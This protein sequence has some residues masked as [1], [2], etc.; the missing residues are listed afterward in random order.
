MFYDLIIVARSSTPK[1][2]QMTQRCIDSAGADNTILVETSGKS[3]TYSGIN[4]TVPYNEPF[5]Y[6][7]A[8][9]IGLLYAKGDIHVLANNDLVF[10]EGWKSIGDYMNEY[11]F[12]SASA[13]SRNS[14]FP[15]GDFIY[16]GF[17]IIHHVTGWCLF[18][19]AEAYK[20]IGKLDES[21]IFW[22]SDNVYATQLQKHKLRHGLFCN[23]R[24]DHITSQ[25]LNMM[26]RKL[27]REYSIGQLAK[28]E[29][30]DRNRER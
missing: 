7:H 12:D 20:K 21:V 11:G 3:F 17:S 8:L 4:V 27:K 5:N 1:L 29:K 26:P 16:E 23:I 22:Y 6:N 19:T 24:V 13:W 15:Q 25:T 14:G 30:Y 2:I 10:H 28:F 9:N 18:I